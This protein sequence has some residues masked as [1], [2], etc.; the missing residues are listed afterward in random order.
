MDIEKVSEFN[1]LNE[2][3]EEFTSSWNQTLVNV[4][5]PSYLKR[6]IFEYC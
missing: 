1:F 2:E 3:I 4:R 5:G 6:K